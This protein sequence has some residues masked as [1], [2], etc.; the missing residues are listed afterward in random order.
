MY[1]PLKAALLSLLKVPPEPHDPMGDVHSLR[2]FRAA[3]GYL[4]Y[5]TVGWIDL[6]RSRSSRR[7]CCSS[8]RSASRSRGHRPW[9]RSP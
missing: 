1:E 7:R 3:P 2:V 9:W 4:R 8:S 6:P 5:I